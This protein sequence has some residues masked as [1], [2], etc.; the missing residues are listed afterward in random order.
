MVEVAWAN[1]AN[2]GGG[3]SY[4]LCKA[5]N[6]TEACFMRGHL[7]FVGGMQW[8]QTQ[9]VGSAPANYTRI[10][11]PRVTVSEGTTPKGSQWVSESTL[12]QCNEP[13]D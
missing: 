11:I 1:T 2:H 6:V 9:Q 10:A 4:R 8:L 7:S 12:A 5:G 3:Y 13:R